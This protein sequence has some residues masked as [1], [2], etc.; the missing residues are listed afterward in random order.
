MDVSTVLAPLSVPSQH[1]RLIRLQA[2]VAGLVVEHVQGR[3][4]VCAPFRFEIDCLST[5]SD[6]DL[7]ALL[8]Q[9]LTLQVLRD[10]GGLRPWHGLCT[11][12]AF[13]GGDGGLTRLRLTL[14]PWTALLALR[15]NAVIFQDLDARAVCER[16]FAQYPQARFRF[17]VQQV[18]PARP[19]TTQYRESDW[20]FV[21]RLLA[22]AG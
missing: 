12:A 11:E 4:A 15:R 22:E 16:I 7:D 13:L 19:I 20:D 2:P 8:E 3:E 17:D 5:R 21:T 10:D 9:P 18:L 14:E 1:A 6:I